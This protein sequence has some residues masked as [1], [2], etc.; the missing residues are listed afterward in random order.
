MHPI[1][2]INLAAQQTKIKSQLESSIQHVLE[3]GQYILGPEVFELE[4]KLSKYTGAEHTISCAN[5]TDA[6]SLL[7]MAK[8]VGHN[9]AVFVPS[10]TFAATAE[11]VAYSGATPIF[12]DV[13]ENTFT[14]SPASLKEAII[15]SQKIGLIPKGIITVDLFGLPA[16]YPAL[17]KIA[18]EH[19]LWIIADA[20]QS[21]GAKIEEKHI[22][23]LCEMT[24]T[25]F[26]PAKP[27]GCYG[28]GGAIFLKSTDK[29][30]E[31]TLRSL[32]AHGTGSGRYDY[33][34]IGINSRLDTLQAAILLEKLKI[35][36]EEYKRRVE[37]ADFY[38]NRLKT[39]V[40]T[41][42]VPENYTH[43]WALYSIRCDKTQRTPLLDLFK[44]EQIPYMIYYEK[45]L[46]L[47]S[48]YEHFPRVQSEL[49]ITEQL[50]K[51]IISIPMHPY[52]TQEQLN[53][54][55]EVIEHGIR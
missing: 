48:A 25:S 24:T 9:D 35:F 19:G 14:M 15:T 10:F 46:H 50:S 31:A 49:K 16:D 6:L 18:Q 13:L 39:M 36:D 26:F 41:P 3:H 54:I 42:I 29:K 1:S 37:I 17:N 12:V 22:G 51:E 45:P 44:R 7:L 43:A 20:A 21:F 27:L 30:M 8:H 32:R 4:E 11:V 23:T 28:D 47:Q 40:Q 34:H 33:I 5:G 2:F 38:T 53:F 52:L 55:V